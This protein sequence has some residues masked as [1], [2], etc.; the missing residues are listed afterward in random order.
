MSRTLST[1]LVGTRLTNE[2]LHADR[3]DG[4][5]EVTVAR[6]ANTRESASLRSAVTEAA[7]SAVETVGLQWWGRIEWVN[8]GAESGSAVRRRH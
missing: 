6:I 1:G 7:A 3:T 8:R 2:R 4:I 5:E